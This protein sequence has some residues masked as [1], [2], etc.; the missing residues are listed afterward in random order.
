VFSAVENRQ[1]KVAVSEASVLSP[2]KQSRE[3]VLLA[4]NGEEVQPLNK[5]SL[6]CRSNA[7]P[8]AAQSTISAMS[9]V[10]P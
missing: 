9:C 6:D 4:D 3:R 1:Q 8:P 7:T 5:T 10:T 2:L